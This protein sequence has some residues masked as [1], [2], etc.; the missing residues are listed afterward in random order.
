[1]LLL[2]FKCVSEWSAY[3]GRSFYWAN[4]SPL[5]RTSASF[6]LGL[7]RV[8]KEKG[9]LPL[10]LGESEPN[11]PPF[12][13]FP[14]TC[15]RPFFP[16][17]F[18]IRSRAKCFLDVP[19]WAHESLF[20][21]LSFPFMLFLYVRTGVIFLP[22]YP[23]SPSPPLPPTLEHLYMLSRDTTHAIPPNNFPGPPRFSPSFPPPV[24]GHGGPPSP[25]VWLIKFPVFFFLIS[26]AP[27]LPP[28]ED[29]Q[30]PF[31]L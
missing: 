9:A 19:R 17:Q 27:L 7:S 2:P 12:L 8:H 25:S 16:V 10:V 4:A 20:G 23:F 14:R 5:T 6:W 18:S 29:H 11:L 30:I 1:L 22:A 24:I 26:N 15:S 21:L 31:F 3:S 28:G 13:F